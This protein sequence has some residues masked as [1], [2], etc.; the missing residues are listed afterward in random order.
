MPPVLDSSFFT[1]FSYFLLARFI[2]FVYFWCFFLLC[3]CK[4]SHWTHSLPA[5]VWNPNR[6]NFLHAHRYSENILY[7]DEKHEI[8]VVVYK[9][10]KAI[11][12][13][14][15]NVNCS[16]YCHVG[17]Y[18]LFVWSVR[19][20]LLFQFFFPTKTAHFPRIFRFKL[21]GKW[22]WN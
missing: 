5:A 15:Y 10:W 20:I 14:A 6:E 18:K 8:T 3:L 21:C 12:T 22:P 17:N 19:W 7:F 4:C 9:V 13:N 11:R 16:A 2:Y 1:F